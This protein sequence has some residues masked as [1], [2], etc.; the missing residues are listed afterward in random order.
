MR[1]RWLPAAMLIAIAA[2]SA[3]L[4]TNALAAA[5]GATPLAPGERITRAAAVA[6]AK[7]LLGRLYVPE[8]SVY[9]SVEPSGTNPVLE[10]APDRPQTPKLI[11]L[12]S[13]WRIPAEPGEVL[14]W[15]EENPPLGSKESAAGGFS[16][17]APG[18]APG[19]FVRFEWRPIPSV[20]ILRS[21]LASVVA[22]PEGSTVLR[23]D[24]QVVWV[25]PRPLSD[26]ILGTVRVLEV[27][28]LAGAA[29]RTV[30]IARPKAVEKIAALI[31]GL[32]VPQ[33]G[34]PVPDG[35][36]IAP[37]PKLPSKLG[38]LRLTFRESANGPPVAE[39]VQMRPAGI[40]NPMMLKIPGHPQVPLSGGG[41]VLPT[42]RT[43]LGYRA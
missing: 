33:P 2:T 20:L 35:G 7:D 37:C 3:M 26:L 30:T 9:S 4:G 39:A 19:R 17:S 29:P 21:L 40:C 38:G 13:W 34:D 23:A 27:R 5:K 36:P 28:R 6:S 12:T 18:G 8:G 32:P 15:L 10:A 22:G 14:S 1:S 41:V 42:L 16:T 24:A 11:D 25:V 43:L 31:N